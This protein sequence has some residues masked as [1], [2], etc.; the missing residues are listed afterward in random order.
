ML[1]S[2]KVLNYIKGEIG[3]P[4]QFVELSDEEILDHIRNYTMKTFAHYF[5]DETT[6]G[7]NVQ[8]ASNKVANKANEF[9]ITDPEGREILGVSHVYYSAGNLYLFGHPP[10]GPMSMGELEQWAFSVEVAGW[11]KSFSSFNYT[12]VFKHPNILSIRPTPNSEQWIAIEY[13]RAHAED[14][15]TI[16]NDLQM[17]FLELALADIGMRIGRLRKKYS[18][19]GAGIPT[20]FGNIPLDDSIFEEFKEKR[21]EVLEKLTAGA[22]T[23]VVVSFG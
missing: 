16:T 20:P 7:L 14:F 3:F 19:G 13:E 5:P 15:S 9:Y 17:Y 22:L 2:T 1:N 18:A 4:W 23:N 10:L 12:H 11:V 8:L 6:I 21:A